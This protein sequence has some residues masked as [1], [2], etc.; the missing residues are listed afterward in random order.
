MD[1]YSILPKENKK[2]MQVAFFCKVSYNLRRK[3][4]RDF[5]SYLKSIIQKDKKTSHLRRYLCQRESGL[6]STVLEELGSP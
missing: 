5:F 4:Q 1:V 2:A 3:N 6:Q